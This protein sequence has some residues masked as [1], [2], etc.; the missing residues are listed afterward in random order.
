MRCDDVFLSSLTLPAW[1]HLLR[2]SGDDWQVFKQFC[3]A[4]ARS[5]AASTSNMLHST[6]DE[7]SCDEPALK[8]TKAIASHHLEVEVEVE[9]VLGCIVQQAKTGYAARFMSN[10]V[11]SAECSEADALMLARWLYRK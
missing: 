8:R 6:A 1:Q 9:D 2:L 4:I 7:S 5:A 3:W 10:V 11:G